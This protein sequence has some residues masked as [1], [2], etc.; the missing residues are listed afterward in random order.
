M[1]RQISKQIVKD[2]Y[3]QLREVST[4]TDYCHCYARDRD[5]ILSEYISDGWN[6]EECN[7]TRNGK[8]YISIY[9][10]YA[11]NAPT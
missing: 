8:Y 4:E 9:R 6:I 2:K 1:N 7:M 11:Q 10:C 5:R 3:G